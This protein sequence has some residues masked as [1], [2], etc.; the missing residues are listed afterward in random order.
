[1]DVIS[2]AQ[3]RIYSLDV[4]EYPI[5]RL[6]RDSVRWEGREKEGNELMGERW[7]EI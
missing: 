1:M 6:S 4:G 7:G 2:S 3:Q 5:E